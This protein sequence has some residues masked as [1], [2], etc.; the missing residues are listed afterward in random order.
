MFVLA[1]LASS[2]AAAASPWMGS[3]DFLRAAYAHGSG[4]TAYCGKGIARPSM[5][6]RTGFFCGRSKVAGSGGTPGIAEV[7]IGF[8]V[9][10]HIRGLSG[11]LSAFETGS[12]ALAAGFARA[13]LTCSAGA[14][15]RANATLQWQLAIEDYQTGQS[16]LDRVGNLW[17][18]G[19]L[20]CPAGHG[21][22]SAVSPAFS[23]A[24]NSSAY[25]SS[26]PVT[27][28][29]NASHPYLVFLRFF[30][31]ADAQVSSGSATAFAACNFQATASS[32]TFTIDGA[33]FG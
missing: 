30:C 16:A 11:N 31:S 21:S 32:N 12:L 25:T 1:L 5:L 3:G 15:G 4:T 26:A 10:E 13:H 18:S 28:S 29:F 17:T 8:S 22:V 19:N 2:V 6:T 23:G 9:R 24:F 7:E 33:T 27:G 14:V 20:S